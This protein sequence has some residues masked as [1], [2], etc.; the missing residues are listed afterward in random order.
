MESSSSNSKEMELQQMQLDERGLHKKCLACTKWKPENFRSALL[1]VLEELDKLIDERVLKY[2]ELQIK[3]REVQA[4]KEIEKRL[5]ESELQR[6]ESLIT[7]DAELEACLVTEGATLKACLVNEGRA[8]DDNLVVKET[9]NDS[10]TLLE[11]LEESNSSQQPHATFPQLDSGL[12]VPTFLPIDDPIACLNKAMAFMSTAF[13]SRFTI[14]DGRLTFQQVQGRQGQNVAGMG[15]K[16]KILLVQAH[17]PDQVLD[18]SSSSGNENRS[19]DY[20]CNRSWNKNRSSDHESTSSGN[21]ANT[22]IGPSYD[23]DIVTQ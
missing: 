3:E 5:K 6:Q 2:E 14:Q 7:E 16:E 9:T 4:I 8:L 12:V 21:D 17:E 13:P 11:Q 15:S 1:R 20:K 23:S 10:V 22:D 19:F 18:E